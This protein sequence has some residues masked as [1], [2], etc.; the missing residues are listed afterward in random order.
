MLTNAWILVLT[1]D[2]N[3]SRDRKR[4]ETMLSSKGSDPS[5]KILP[6]QCFSITSIT[7]PPAGNKCPIY[8]LWEQFIFKSQETKSQNEINVTQ[9]LWKSLHRVLVINSPPTMPHVLQVPPNV[10]NTTLET[11]LLTLKF[12]QTTSK[13][14]Q[15]VGSLPLSGVSVVVG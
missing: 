7:V 4:L 3:H 11:I 8:D 12:T 6:A 14:Y 15:K 13:L 2:R 10:N 9:E 5:S 1:I